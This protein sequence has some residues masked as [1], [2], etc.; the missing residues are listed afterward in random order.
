VR[1]RQTRERRIF[2]LEQLAFSLGLACACACDPITTEVGAWSPDPNLYLEAESGVLAGGFS[3]GEDAGASRGRYIAPPVGVESDVEPGMARAVYSF[4]LERDGDYV[5]WGRLRAPGALN[6]RFWFQVDGGVWTKW[7]I[8]VGDIWYWDDFHRDTDYGNTLTF[9][10]EAGK[11]ELVLANCV[12]GVALDRLFFSPT[13]VVP[14]GNDTACHPPHSIELEGQCLPSC[15][16]QDG[17]TC[18][19]VACEGRD[20]ISAYDCAVCCHLEQ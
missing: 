20:L 17:T 18:D 10:L 14:P 9:P 7:R 11:H 6:N 12:D 4:S 19:A 1:G 13:G 15:G 5:I 3:I 2:S 8:S 16:A